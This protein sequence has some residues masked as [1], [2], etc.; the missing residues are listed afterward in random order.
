MIALCGNL[1]QAGD[2]G[3]C[4]A[5]CADCGADACGAKSCCDDPGSWIENTQFWLGG[6]S[7]KGIGETTQPAGP[8]TGFM[9]SAGPVTGFNSGFG[10][11]DSE[12]R[13]QL[14]ASFGLYDLKG[15]DS[16]AV[17]SSL[18][19]QYFITGGFYKR[20]NIC[21]DDRISWAIVYDGFFG[22]NWGVVATDLY[23]GQFRSLVGY[24]LNDSN[25]VGIW[26]TAR[27]NTATDA[28]G[29]T[30]RAM[31]QGN[32]Y[33]R[34]HYDFGGTTMAYAGSVDPAD[35]ASWQFGFLGAAP[36][37]H[38][39]SLYGSYVYS[40]PG[41][42]TGVVGSNEHLWDFSVGLMYSFGGKA[43]ARN[44]SGQQGLP[45]LPVANN[46]SLMLTN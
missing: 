8:V 2:C 23:V 6:E 31:S 24:A 17:N 35:V 34:H 26:T 7:Y 14:G 42:A 25:E 37:N 32:L 38:N 28:L 29:T 45:L 33:W 9:A 36:L 18:E 12:V 16:S 1:V 44:I 41:S 19:Q 3:Q 5:P 4:D 40:F 11:G 20:S 39:L 13:G 21:T 15:R 27:T 22:Q 46:G 30:Y 43:V 10:L